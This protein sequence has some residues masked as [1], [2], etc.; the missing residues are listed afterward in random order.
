MSQAWCAQFIQLSPISSPCDQHGDQLLM[1]RGCL[2]SE[3]LSAGL[4]SCCNLWQGTSYVA[5]VF[6]CGPFSHGAI[7]RED[8]R[9]ARGLQAVRI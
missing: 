4:C 6:C 8:N 2:G 9:Q 3:Y 7:D 1:A 5:A